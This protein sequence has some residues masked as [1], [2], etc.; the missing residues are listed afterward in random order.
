MVLAMEA[1]GIRLPERLL[2]GFR[3]MLILLRI[4]PRRCREP[5]TTSEPYSMWR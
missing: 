3:A 4:T 1:K 5:C 2:S